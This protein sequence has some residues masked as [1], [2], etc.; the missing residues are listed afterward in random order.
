MYKVPLYIKV[1]IRWKVSFVDKKKIVIVSLE[2]KFFVHGEKHC[3]L[4]IFYDV[5]V[6]SKVSVLTS[7]PLEWRLGWLFPFNHLRY[8]LPI[9][10]TPPEDG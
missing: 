6:N 1:Y 9:W 10:A 5:I 2:T 7:F 8:R 4:E 3:A